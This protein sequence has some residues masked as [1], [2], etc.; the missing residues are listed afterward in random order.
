MDSISAMES[1]WICESG[2]LK[3]TVDREV[4]DFFNIMNIRVE[5]N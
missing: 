1:M 5:K 3:V 2:S 4:T